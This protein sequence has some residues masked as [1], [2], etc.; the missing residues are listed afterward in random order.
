MRSPLVMKLAADAHKWGMPVSF[1]RDDAF[2]VKDLCEQAGIPCRVFGHHA[3]FKMIALIDSEDN[4]LHMADDGPFYSVG[5]KLIT[6]TDPA[7]V[8]LRI[9]EILAYTFHEYSA[10]ECLNGQ[11]LFTVPPGAYG[12]EVS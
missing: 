3:D 11:N 7:D 9:L 6:E 4:F 8:A 1:T 12:T 2:S 10:R 5:R